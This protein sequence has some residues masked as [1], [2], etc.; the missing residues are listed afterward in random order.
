MGHA[1]VVNETSN[2]YENLLG[3]RQADSA[4]VLLIYRGDW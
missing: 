4:I 2:V 1:G 3:L